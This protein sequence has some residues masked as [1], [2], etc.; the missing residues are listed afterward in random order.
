MEIP[1]RISPAGF[2]VTLSGQ[3]P[4]V[5]TAPRHKPKDRRTVGAKTPDPAT[6]K[7]WEDVLDAYLTQ[8][9]FFTTKMT[10]V[11]NTCRDLYA[12][13]CPKPFYSAI[14]EGCIEQGKECKQWIYPSMVHDFAMVIAVPM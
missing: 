9:K 6:F 10:E 7:S 8:V 2:L 11:E 3:V 14:V 13:Y 5:G 1:G 12:K 4:V